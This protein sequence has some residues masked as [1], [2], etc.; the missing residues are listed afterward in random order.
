M[1]E[2]LAFIGKSSSLFVTILILLTFSLDVLVGA[3]GWQSF[4]AK[5]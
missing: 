2:L 4:A 5:L 1:N 3:D